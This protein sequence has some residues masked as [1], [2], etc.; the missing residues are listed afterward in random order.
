M[1]V[2]ELTCSFELTIPPT[3]PA[4]LG[5]TCS[6]ITRTMVGMDMPMPSPMASSAS[7]SSGNG[8]IVPAGDSVLMTAVAM[9][10]PADRTKPSD[11]AAGPVQRPTKGLAVDPVRKLAEKGRMASSACSAVKPS[12]V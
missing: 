1:P 3:S 4:R 5:S 7:P 10:P 9:A 11:G 8:G 2:A 6:T 12:A